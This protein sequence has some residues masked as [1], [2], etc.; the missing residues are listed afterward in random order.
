M[1]CVFLDTNILHSKSVDFTKARFAEKLEELIDEIEVNDLYQYVKLIIP[2]LVIS[3]LRK[4]QIDD[5]AE[6]VKNS[7]YTKVTEQVIELPQ[8]YERICDEVFNGTLDSFCKGVMKVEI[9]PYPPNE[10]LQ[11][12]IQRA[13]K[14]DPPFEAKEKES[15]KG[16]KDAL[17]WESLKEYK[18]KN[19][20]DTIVLYSKDKR[21][22]DIFLQKEYKEIFG[23]DIHMIFRDNPNTHEKLL[24]KLRDLSGIEEARESFSQQLKNQVVDLI[25][26]ISWV[27][28]VEPDKIY[29]FDNEQVTITDCHVK[30]VLITNEVEDDDVISFDLTLDVSYSANWVNGGFGNIDLECSATVNY[31]ISADKFYFKGAEGPD[32]TFY[33]FNGIGEEL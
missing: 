1:I 5:C 23:E 3:E 19:V 21:I 27:Y 29:E 13:I 22:V 8:D 16:F 24:D 18:K 17:I 20:K 31:S 26:D 32:G 28:L 30:E 11:N 10:V 4:Q 2:Q 25:K 14:K 12:L 15:D 9:A 33:E 6:T 7:R